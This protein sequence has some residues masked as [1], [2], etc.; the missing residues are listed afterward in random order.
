MQA[1]V[2]VRAT[3]HHAILPL[4]GRAARRLALLA[5]INE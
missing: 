5:G 4:I 3:R 2:G 1:G